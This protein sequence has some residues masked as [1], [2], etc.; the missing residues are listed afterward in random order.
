MEKG[1]VGT[2]MFQTI[3]LSFD[4]RRIERVGQT[5]FSVMAPVSKKKTETI[6]RKTLRTSD[7]L[8]PAKMH[9][10]FVDIDALSVCPLY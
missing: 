3:Y 2:G 10:L 4:V 8:S 6:T 7:H 1:G 9:A 5:I